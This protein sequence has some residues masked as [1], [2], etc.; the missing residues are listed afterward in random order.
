LSQAQGLFAEIS[1]QLLEKE[2]EHT[3][4]QETCYRTEAE[5]TAAR[6]RVAELNLESERTRGRLA[7]QAKQIGAIDERLTAN[8]TE[9]LDLETRRL[10]EQTDLDAHAATIARLEAE[11]TSLNERLLAKT[12]ERDALQ[13]DL[14]ERERALEIY[15]AK[16]D[17]PAA[18]WARHAWD[19]VADGRSSALTRRKHRHDTM[20]LEMALTHAQFQDWLDRYVAAWKSYDPQQIGEFRILRRVGQLYAA[21]L[22]RVCGCDQFPR[23]TT[24]KPRW[25]SEP[26]GSIPSLTRS[27]RSSLSF[28]SSA[29]SGRTST[30][31]LVSSAIGMG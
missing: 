17:R 4:I 15:E 26:V 18:A 6:A 24:A 31:F 9:T 16:G 29:P 25:M 12:T 13:D 11:S 1:A 30:A 27:G 19:G 21:E 28:A 20:E 23:S 7:L 14:R 10:Q 3:R 8:E 2:G 22:V 5:L